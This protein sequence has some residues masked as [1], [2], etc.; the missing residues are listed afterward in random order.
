[1][2]RIIAGGMLV[3]LLSGCYLSIPSFYD[4]NE[5]LLAVDVRMSVA[6]LDCTENVRP[7]VVSVDKTI[8][9]LALYSESKG[10]N[11]VGEMIGMMRKTTEGML[12]KETISSAFCGIKRKILVKQSD[13]VATAIM[14]RY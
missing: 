5:S 3:L 1:M 10:S 13:D 4:E 8:Q 6:N 9:R 7:Q 12:Q 14:G 2:S 11:D